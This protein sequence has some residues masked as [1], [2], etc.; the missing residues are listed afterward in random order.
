MKRRLVAIG[1]LVAVVGGAVASV[2]AQAPRPAENEKVINDQNLFSPTRSRP[3]PPPAPKPKPVAAP[4]PPPPPPKFMLSGVVL[5]GDTEIAL[6]QEPSLT[7]N[8]VR[9][10]ARR[11]EIGSYTLTAV[12]EDRVE[13]EGPAGKITVPLSGP[14]RPTAA[15][16][17]VAPRSPR[18]PRP[19]A[20]PQLGAPGPAGVLLRGGGGTGGSAVSRTPPTPPSEEAPP[21]AMAPA[22][23]KPAIQIPLDDPRRGEGFKGLFDALQQSLQPSPA[24]PSRTG[25]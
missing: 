5:D 13:L 2:Q 18:P 7:Q 17:A 16:A 1:V 20:L 25:Q 11:G 9:I 24:E 21:E 22:A 15:T 6:L 10:V 4:L 8:Q 3:A 23:P 12:L 19:S 14:S